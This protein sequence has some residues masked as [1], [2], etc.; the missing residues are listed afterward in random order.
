VIGDQSL[1]AVAA[2]AANVEEVVAEQAMN[3]ASRKPIVISFP[4]IAQSFRKL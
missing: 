2:H 4:S 3:P 1:G